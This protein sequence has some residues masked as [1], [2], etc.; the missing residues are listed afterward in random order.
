MGSLPNLN[1]L[2][3]QQRLKNEYDPDATRAFGAASVAN[4]DKALRHERFQMLATE[5]SKRGGGGGGVAGGGGGWH[6]EQR[7]RP[8]S[9]MVSRKV[10]RTHSSGMTNHIWDDPMIEVST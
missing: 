6:I 8:R 1:D 9:S 2:R 5:E 3:E 7:Q 4:Q 10:H